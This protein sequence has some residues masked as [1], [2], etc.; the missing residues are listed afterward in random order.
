MKKTALITADGF[1]E[2][3]GLTVVDLLR[4]AG[5]VCDIVSLSG[6]GEITGS[7][8]IRIAADRSFGETDFDDYDAVILPGGQP[9]TDTFL[10]D[11]R[12]KDLLRRFAAAGRLTAA[13]CAAPT[14]LAAAGLLEG[15]KAVCYP[16][17]EGRLT[18]AEVLYEPAV[19]D[20]NVIT[21][22][23]VGTAIPFALQIICALEG[24]EAAESI[25]KK[26]VFPGLAAEE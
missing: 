3:E 2:V 26:I 19:Q 10:A 7:H 12:V 21:G 11:G 8:G 13:V 23:S 22:R 14:V 18:G 4:R 17:L 5:I 24:K 25:R 9:G 16:G 20:G 1:E 6:A 15:K